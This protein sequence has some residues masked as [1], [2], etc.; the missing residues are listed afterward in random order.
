LAASAG[1]LRRTWP[2]RVYVS[3][4]RDA[5]PR[6]PL[7]E[8]HLRGVLGWPEL[9]VAVL[10]SP[11]R[12]QKK[13][14]LQL[15]LDGVTRAYAKVGWNELTRAL[16]RTE[17]RVLAS[18][19]AESPPSSFRV[20]RMLY[21]GGCG[22]LELVVVEAPAGRLWYDPRRRAPRSLPV[23][24]TRELASLAPTRRRPLA[25][26][27]FL[28]GR[29]REVEELAP[30]RDALPCSLLDLIETEGAGS[31]LDFGFAHG[32]WVPWN[33]ARTRGG[34]VVWDWERAEPSA[35]VGLDA[36]HFLFQLHL[37]FRKR[38]PADAV[39]GTL[40]GARHL[41]PRLG[42]DARTAPLLLLLH[43]LQMTIRL[44]QGRD[45]GI[46]GVIPSERYRRSVDAFEQRARRR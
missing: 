5:E 4:P 45:G 32:D 3:L 18:L 31:E 24:A 9:E 40:R 25:Q 22:E 2:N 38:S 8:S 17:S 41:L 21:T 10:F 7:V 19:H 42:V 36:V 46:G 39:D 44:E 13:P 28:A 16:V 11:G 12:P 35:P 20:P 23:D 34:L 6:L 33:M 1:L 27:G 14:V 37:N 15:I 30:G 43:L 26:S 29:R